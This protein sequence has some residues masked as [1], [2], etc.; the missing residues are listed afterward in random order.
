MPVSLSALSM[1][2][3]NRKKE[4]GEILDYMLAIVKKIKPA[5]RG[6]PTRSAAVLGFVL[7]GQCKS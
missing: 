7:A 2:D 3:I 1:M 4:Q 6:S 5:R